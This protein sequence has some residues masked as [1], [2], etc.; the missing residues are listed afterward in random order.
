[1]NSLECDRNKEKFL[2]LKT[3]L[4]IDAFTFKYLKVFNK[5]MIDGKV[6]ISLNIQ[7]K[8][9]RE[10]LKCFKKQIRQSDL[11][12]IWVEDQDTQIPSLKT[13]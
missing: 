3:I 8:I 10:K 9:Y 11:D 12:Y 5:T 6:F 7:L 2:G 4:F 13:Y 1:M